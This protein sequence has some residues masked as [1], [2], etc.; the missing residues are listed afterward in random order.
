MLTITL[1][2]IYPNFANLLSYADKGL[3]V[4]MMSQLLAIIILVVVQ[5]FWNKATV[6]LVIFLLLLFSTTHVVGTLG[7]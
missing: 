6:T 2:S 5:H 7:A 3:T 4:F 1:T